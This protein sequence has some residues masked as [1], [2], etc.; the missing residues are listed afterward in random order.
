MDSVIDS[1]RDGN[2]YFQLTDEG[3]IEKYV[4]VLIEDIKNNSFEM[5]QYLLVRIIIVSLSLDENKTRGRNT[6]VGKPLINCD[7]DGCPKSIN[8]YI[9][10]L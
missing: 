6:P 8:G 9:E 2:E 5:R 10:E 1:P 4:G 7:L 3:N